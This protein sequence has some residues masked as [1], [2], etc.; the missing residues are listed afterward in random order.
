MSK[1]KYIWEKKTDTELQLWPDGSSE[2]Y[3]TDPFVPAEKINKVGGRELISYPSNMARDFLRCRGVLSA[4]IT[5][6]KKGFY[7]QRAGAEFHVLVFG[8]G[9]MATLSIVRD[10]FS[11]KRGDVLVCPSHAAYG[12]SC[13]SQ[14]WDTFWF[15]LENSARW[16]I[17][18][19]FPVIRKSKSFDKL[20]NVVNAFADELYGKKLSPVI[21]ESYASLITEFIIREISN[22]G[23]SKEIDAVENALLSARQNLEAKWSAKV[24][25]KNLG[26]SQKRFNK[27][28]VELHSETF[29]KIIFRNRMLKA[30]ELLLGGNSV[31][32]VAAV[33]GYSDPFSF[34]KAFKLYYGKA[35]Q[36]FIKDSLKQ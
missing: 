21:L 31:A 26:M 23:S 10:K 34:S 25:A 6:H 7:Q 15:H 2:R 19:D 3:L 27:L 22:N 16:E 5:R 32:E 29:S 12:F 11:L 18:P 36:L 17:A 8:T 14:N 13:D 4:G 24:I 9:G 33:S 35:P 30:Y 28:C 20:E 1:S